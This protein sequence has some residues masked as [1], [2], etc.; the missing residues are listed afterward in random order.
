MVEYKH[1]PALVILSCPSFSKPVETAAD[2]RERETCDE[3]F[4]LTTPAVS[5]RFT[6]S[7]IQPIEIPGEPILGEA[8]HLQDCENHRPGEVQMNGKDI[9]QTGGTRCERELTVDTPS[10]VIVDTSYLMSSAGRECIECLELGAVRSA[11]IDLEAAN[12]GA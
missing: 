12:G 1:C 8:R 11:T 3:S 9:H 6:F 2:A 7:V 4:G 5:T 10:I